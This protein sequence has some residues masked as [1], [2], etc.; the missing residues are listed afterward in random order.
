MNISGRVAIVTGGGS[1]LGEATARM[2][3][4]AGAKVAVLDLD[5][6]G[7]E[8]VAG[9]VDGLAIPLDVADARAAE[10]AVDE[11]GQTLGQPRILVNCAGVAPA[12][13]IVGRNG[14]MPLDAFERVVR[15]NLIG[16]F[17]MMRLAAAAMAQGEPL[18]DGE[19]GVVVNTA[20]V[21]AFEGQVGQAAYAAS[22]GGVASPR[23]DPPPVT[24][25]TRPEMFMAAA[26]GDA[27]AR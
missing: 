14:P 23:P 19:R 26:L 20:S 6:A 4:E 22:K 13:K 2:L 12:A 3:A 5:R 24:I 17:N 21:A 27:Q 16:T 9:A 15:V 7:A 10:L 11:V 1:G 25:A 18:A 8:R